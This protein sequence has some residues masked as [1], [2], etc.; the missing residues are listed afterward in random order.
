MYDTSRNYFR[1]GRPND[2]CF[3]TARYPYYDMAKC[4]SVSIL[5]KILETI[6]PD[7]SERQYL[8][9]HLSSALTG[10]RPDK[11]VSA[12]FCQVWLGLSNDG[13]SFLAKLIRYTF[14]DY[15]GPCARLVLFEGDQVMEDVDDRM[16]NY[17]LTFP[18]SI[19]IRQ[20]GLQGLVNSRTP[21]H[22]VPFYTSTYCGSLYSNYVPE[23]F[24]HDFAW[25]LI[26]KQAKWRTDVA[27][28]T[29]PRNIIPYNLP[30]FTGKQFADKKNSL[31][32]KELHVADIL[33]N[34]R[35][36]D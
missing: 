21:V 12:S 11:S 6:I 22:L 3:H 1:A 2:Y 36:L 13:R 20:V 5:E 31:S 9:S 4:E 17:L 23:Q 8:L 26:D 35:N 34:L 29:L 27:P 7:L 24:Y 10:I 15:L 16:L 33:C 32:G 30:T 28:Q 19:W 14:G 18:K 25:L